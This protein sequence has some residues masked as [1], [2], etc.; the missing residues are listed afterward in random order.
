MAFP[1]PNFQRVS[2][3]FIYS[4]TVTENLFGVFLIGVFFIT[5]LLISYKRNEGE[6]GRSLVGASFASLVAGLP[7]YAMGILALPPLIALFFI[8]ILSLFF[9]SK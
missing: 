5:I 8:G 9:M 6:L 4:N 2:D 3:L 1:S 7:L